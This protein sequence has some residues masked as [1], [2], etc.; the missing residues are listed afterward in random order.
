VKKFSFSLRKDLKKVKNLRYYLRCPGDGL[1]VKAI[2]VVGYYGALRTD[3]QTHMLWSYCSR[4]P[5]GIWMNFCATSKTDSAGDG[6][7]FLI[8]S[9]DELSFSAFGAYEN[10]LPAVLRE[11]RMWKTWSFRNNKYHNTP[12]GKSFISEVPKRVATFLKKDPDIFTGH[13]WRR[14]SATI[15]ANSGLS[16]L[17]LKQHGRWKSDCVAQGYVENSD[18]AKEKA[19]SALAPKSNKR[20]AEPDEHEAKRRR[21]DEKDENESSGEYEKLLSF[22]GVSEVVIHNL[23]VNVNKKE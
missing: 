6:F 23:T 8:P 4:V 17:E 20:P 3:E 11:G 5:D 13:T 12:V 2:V 19:A 7:R 16:L 22:Q 9:T 21:K 15:V 14:T 18:V 10:S 1:L